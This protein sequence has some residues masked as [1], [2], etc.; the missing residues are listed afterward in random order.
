MRFPSE[1]ARAKEAGKGETES[2]SV[3]ASVMLGWADGVECSHKPAQEGKGNGQL[4]GR[5]GSANDAF[6]ASY[7]ALK[8]F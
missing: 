2:G 7:D 3:H 1:L 5:E 6:E 4:G 8:P